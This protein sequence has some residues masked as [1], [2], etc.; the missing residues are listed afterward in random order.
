M[1]E[2]TKLPRKPKKD[3]PA[4]KSDL[5]FVADL[6]RYAE[7][8][9]FHLRNMKA[10]TEAT[11]I[12]TAHGWIVRLPSHRRD[13]QM[14]QIIRRTTKNGAWDPKMGQVTPLTSPS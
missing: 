3:L 7:G 14:W 9:S 11:E 13:R 12:L 2:I 1:S 10:I 8:H 6:A 5:E 4:L